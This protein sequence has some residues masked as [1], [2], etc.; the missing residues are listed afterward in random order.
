M[1]WA[2]QYKPAFVEMFAAVSGLPNDQPYTLGP[3]S[4]FT[5]I[6][7]DIQYTDR[8][9]ANLGLGTPRSEDVNGL[10]DTTTVMKLHLAHQDGS[11]VGA[12]Q[13][14]ADNLTDFGDGEALNLV[15]LARN[16]S[17]DMADKAAL[18]A[19]LSVREQ[20]MVLLDDRRYIGFQFSF[21]DPESTTGVVYSGQ[22]TVVEFIDFRG[23]TAFAAMNF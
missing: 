6:L 12:A 20:D 11:D 22:V 9:A 18:S 16:G 5:T 21:S 15:Y 4:D 13:A 1:S 23:D 19:D 7:K 3:G 10:L 17:Y 14:Y 8:L 2:E